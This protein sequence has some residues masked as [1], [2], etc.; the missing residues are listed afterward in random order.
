MTLRKNPKQ[1]DPDYENAEPLNPRH[2][3]VQVSPSL[4]YPRR[5]EAFGVLRQGGNGLEAGHKNPTGLPK[6]LLMHRLRTS[7]PVLGTRYSIIM[8]LRRVT[9][10]APTRMRLIMFVILSVIIPRSTGMTKALTV[11]RCFRILSSLP[12]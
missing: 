11:Q 4:R 8:V 1:Q 2:P 5:W 10:L 3:K 7:G 12:S 9:R 6:V